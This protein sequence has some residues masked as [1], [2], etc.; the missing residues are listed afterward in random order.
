ME[1]ELKTLLEWSGTVL[2]LIG[3]LLLAMNTRA[4]R[5][6]WV[7]F[8]GAN[9]CVAGFALEIGAN[10]LLMQQLG[11]T[12]TSLLGILRSDFA[13][14][15]SFRAWRRMWFKSTLISR[16]AVNRLE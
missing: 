8:L 3:A 15:Q 16:S 14:A 5:W 9:I 2:G 10:G 13:L 11:F 6:G 4:S 7:A 12:A 1:V